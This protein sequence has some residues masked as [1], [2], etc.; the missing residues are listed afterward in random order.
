MTHFQSNKFENYQ[1]DILFFCFCWLLQLSGPVRKDP[2]CR[3][4]LPKP[5]GR[6]AEQRKVLGCVGLYTNQYLKYMDIYN[7]KKKKKKLTWVI[8]FHK[9]RQEKFHSEKLVL[10]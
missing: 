6:V 1:P 3:L 9:R 8:T 4:Q 7:I 5:A 10:K 2:G